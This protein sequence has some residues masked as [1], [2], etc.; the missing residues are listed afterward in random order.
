MLSP[1]LFSTPLLCPGPGH[2]AEAGSARIEARREGNAQRRGWVD[3]PSLSAFS[4]ELIP[5][6]V[7]EALVPHSGAQ[8]PQHCVSFLWMS[9]GY[10]LPQWRGTNRP[11]RAGIR[12]HDFGL[13]FHRGVAIIAEKTWLQKRRC[14]FIVLLRYEFCSSRFLCNSDRPMRRLRFCLLPDGAVSCMLKMQL[15]KERNHESDRGGVSR[16]GTN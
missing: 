12:L 16:I 1:A 8:R 6:L 5:I 3:P 10:H 7:G 14:F 15:R 9:T 4:L 11:T 2:F 13:W